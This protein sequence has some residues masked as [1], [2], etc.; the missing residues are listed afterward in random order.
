MEKTYEPGAIEA[1][2]RAAWEQGGWFAAGQHT[3]GDGEGYAVMIPPPNVTGTL[4]MGHA[5]QHTIQDALIRHAR[6]SGKDTL[7][8]MGTD[9]A[10]IATQMVVERNLKLAGEPSRAELGRDKFLEKVWEW[11]KYSAGTIGQQI[12]RMGS[13]VDWSREAFTMDPAYNEAV[14]EHFVKLHEDGLIYR[15]KRLVNWDPVLQTAISDLEVVSEDE[16]GKLWHLRYPLADG[17]GQ[18]LIV[19]T[20]RPETLLGDTAVAVH[21]EDERY[22][23]LIGKT[24]LLPLANREIPIIA[25]D[26]VDREFGTGVVKITP[27]HDFNDYQVGQRHKLAQ[28]NVLTKDAKIAEGF[29]YA[30]LDRY[31]AR[32]QMVADLEAA[33]GLACAPATQ[34]EDGK[35]LYPRGLVEKIE[36]H[37]L[38]VPRGDRSG[39]VLEPYLTDQ[40]FVD[41]TRQQL[42]DGR[43]GGYT[44]ITKPAIDAVESG[45]IRFVPDNW[46]TTYFHWLNNIQDW[47]ISRQLWWG[48]RIP[49]WY[50]TTNCTY[51]SRNERSAVAAFEAEMQA[52][53]KALTQYIHGDNSGIGI[54][55][56][57]IA[58]HHQYEALPEQYFFD[59]NGALQEGRRKKLAELTQPEKKGAVEWLRREIEQM[60]DFGLIQDNDVFDTWFSSDIWP[61]ATLGWPQQTPELRKYYPGAVLVTGF[62]IIFFWVARMVMM[63]CYFNDG[64]VPFKDVFITGLVRDPE[65]NK[66]SKSKGNVLDPLD[67]VDGI[68]LDTLVKKRTTGLM[69]P[70]TAPKIEAKTRKDYPK[71]IAPVGVDALRFTFAALATNGRDVR[72]DAGRAEGYR[73]FCNKI[74]NA[75]RFVLMNLG[76][77]DAETGAALDAPSLDGEATLSTADRWIISTLQRVEAEAAQHY[78]DY[79]FDLLAQTLYQFIWNEYCDWYLELSKPA[80]LNGNDEQKRGTRRTLVR[81]LEAW[82]RLLHPLMPFLTEEIW[83]KVAPLAG[84]AGGSI[85]VQPYP[86][87][88]PEKIDPAAEAD[89]EWLKALILG[90]RQIRAQMDISPGKVLPLLVQNASASDR[91]RLTRLSDSVVFLARVEAPKLLAADETAPESSTALLGEAK[92]LV[93][94]AGLIDKG[95][96]LARLAKQIAKLEADLVLTNG[97]I[98]NPN[99]GKAP[100]AVQ[101]KTRDLI[102]QQERDLAALKAQS[103]RIEAL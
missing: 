33:T 78:A 79:R 71:G 84:K 60:R 66:M 65:G 61:F 73:N 55:E 21:P 17:S 31:A 42:A 59:E 37:K 8:Q 7:W 44:R 83:Q 75:S 54:I 94:M 58:K 72:F 63:G 90:V 88:Q 2:W 13:S 40:W 52:V 36:D 80:L 50:S 91:E 102:A 35:P 4:H 16:N 24:V 89:I 70:E 19:A 26:F 51:V 53:E 49:A 57:F 39:A 98:A 100:E 3:P 28:I 29:P 11:K 76:A 32:K 56:T 74:W 20:T 64:E 101:Q 47:C 87:S 23:H 38:K 69:K 10:G 81:V 62:D 25:D 93:P 15:G 1:R 45:R 92:L 86:V 85:M 9:H 12:R 46:K 34:N 95:A 41:L 103:A 97:R 5:F 96:E 43:P 82:L 18:Y 6:M 68:D 22:Q 14:I 27:A 48:H 30:G 67:V 99:F 77:I